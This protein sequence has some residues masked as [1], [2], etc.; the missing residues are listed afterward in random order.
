MNV[1]LFLLISIIVHLIPIPPSSEYFRPPLI[2]HYFPLRLVWGAGAWLFICVM[3]QMTLPWALITLV[4]SYSLFLVFNGVSSVR[5]KRLDDMR[6]TMPAVCL[7]I[8]LL[9]I[10]PTF[11]GIVSWTSD[12]SNAEYVDKFITTAKGP[13]FNS[14][15]EDS[16]VR[17]VT[18]QLARFQARR[19][20]NSIGSNVEI[21]AA[22]ITTRNGR[23]VWV[24][25]VVSTNT[26]SENRLQGLIV[27]D[28]N[29][30]NQVEVITDVG[31]MPVGEGLWWDKNIQFGNY[32]EDMTNSYEYAYPTWDPSGQL[33]YIQTRTNLGADFVERP[34]GPKVYYYN[35]TVVAYPTLEDT[36]E[37][38][39]QAYGEEW[40]ERQITRWGSYRR[41]S[42]FDLFASGFLWIVEP[43]RDRITITEDTRYII[44]PD[45]DHVEALVAVHPTDATSLTLSG[46]MQATKDKIY[47]HDMRNMS[48][49]S[50][51]AAVNVVLKTFANPTSGAYY[52]AMPLIYPIQ[53]NSTYRRWAWYVPIYWYNTQYDSDSEE[54][55][56]TDIRLHGL[57]IVDGQLESIKAIST[58]GSGET[59]VRNVREAY[60]QAVKDALSVAPE[61]SSKLTLTANVLNV[62]S[63]VDEGSTHILIRTDNATYQWIEG[64]KNWMALNDWYTLLT[65]KVGDNF[66]ATLEQVGNQYRIT[67]FKKN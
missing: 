14:T 21:A 66:T 58:T 28:A 55:V 18:S 61:P 5:V 42:G 56:L 24:C 46:F 31:N 52:G 36:P 13:L 60:V 59:L 47:Y 67:S 11:S 38:I 62:T 41:G 2:F 48:L 17:L 37:W 22:H 32:L 15:I 63:Y 30:P 43:S 50:G 9:I 4:M 54:T 45:N 8:I 35:G 34:L 64:A 23:L 12:V 29:D 53:I 10:V 20:M 25:V 49:M 7:G 27:V 16:K 39:T 40:L 51:E 65:V 3:M 26:L 44:N 6:S 1:S 57:G 33:V 19:I